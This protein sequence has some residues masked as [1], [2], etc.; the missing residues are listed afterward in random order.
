M[1]TDA[2]VY[3]VWLTFRVG[4][5]LHTK[6][7]ALTATIL[8]KTVT[9]KSVKNDQP[10]CKSFWLIASCTGFDSETEAKAFGEELRR[11]VHLAGLGTKVGVDA[12]DPGEDRTLSWTNPEIPLGALRDKHPD[13]KLAPDVHGLVVL[14]DDGNYIFIRERA[15]GESRANTANFVKALQQA[16][17][18]PTGS[19]DE[20]S[21]PIR[22]AIRL[23]N[24]AEMSNDSI[25]KLARAVA[26][27]EG[28]ADRQSRSTGHRL[29]KVGERVKEM[30]WTH[31]LEDHWADWNYL[32]NKRSRLFHD[33]AV[34]P[35][36]ALGSYLDET[37]LHE[38]GERASKLCAKIILTIAKQAG[39]PVPEQAS[40]HFGV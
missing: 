7:T 33:D 37:E 36:E 1:T 25:A 20:G 26:A 9:M 40:V 10:L 14:P 6:E 13:L 38:L 30:M 31:G 5:R 35:G 23:L 16:L 3:G 21:R 2:T 4:K 15:S 24:L 32:Y 22:R 29:D 12:R 17:S 39:I 18:S 19:G 11:A 34:D 27:V 28:L 8:G